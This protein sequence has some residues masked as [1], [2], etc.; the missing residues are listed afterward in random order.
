M[1]LQRTVGMIGIERAPFA[2][3]NTLLGRDAGEMEILGGPLRYINLSR[4]L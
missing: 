4:K 1:R 3:Q 2:R